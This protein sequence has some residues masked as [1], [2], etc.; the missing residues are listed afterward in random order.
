[1]PS[2]WRW[3]RNDT[4]PISGTIKAGSPRVAVDI[5]SATL[6]FHMLNKTL[7][8]TIVDAA[9]N[10]DQTGD[11]SDGT[12]GDW[13][14]DPAAADTDESGSFRGEVEVTFA[15]STIRTFP[16]KGFFEINIGD[17]LL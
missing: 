14:Y 1:M 13:S 2:N 12:K 11:G 3:K 9:A 5:Q 4:N 8:E 10:N 16:T 6:R 7:T 17:D 15:D